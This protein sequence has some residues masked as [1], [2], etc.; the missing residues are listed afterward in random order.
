MQLLRLEMK[1]FKSFADKTIVQFSPGMTAIV[2]PN[3]SGKSNITDAMRWVLGESNIRNL[4]GQKAEDIIFAGTEKRRPMSTAEVTLVFDNSD[5]R[6]G[7]GKAEVAVTRRIYRNGDSEFYINKESC[8]LKDIQLLLADTG[9]GRDSMAIIGQN[10]VDAILNSKAEE[11]RLI[12]ED[13]AGISRFK[14]NKEDAL[15]RINATE[16]NM[17]RVGDVMAKL[18]EQLVPMGEAAAKTTEHNRLA[19]EKR[20]YDG[21]LAFHDYKT[22][23]RLF[24][25]WENEKLGADSALQEVQARLQDLDAKREDV[26][27]LLATE[28]E[29]VRNAED[30][31]GTLRQEAES[32]RGRREIIATQ[33]KAEEKAAADLKARLDGWQDMRDI[34]SKFGG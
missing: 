6:L 30:E 11:R 9:L 18:E 21:A 17:E 12:F 14:L 26:K 24:T 25:R 27:N 29:R 3:G 22:A 8:R 20:D 15:R 28:R 34:R 31:F 32:W 5:G 33:R 10:R 19:R 7:E 13:V 4:R 1:G 2:G 16:R 23:D